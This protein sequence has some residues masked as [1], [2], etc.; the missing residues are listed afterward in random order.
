MEVHVKR[1]KLFIIVF[2]LALLTVFLPSMCLAGAVVTN[3][4][5]LKAKMDFNPGAV[6]INS[7]SRGKS[8]QVAQ[9][10]AVEAEEVPAVE[11]LTISLRDLFELVQEKNAEIRSK[12]LE[13]KNSGEV[14]NIERAIFEPEFVS[15]YQHEENRYRTS[16]KEKVSLG[17]VDIFDERNNDLDLAIEGLVQ[18]GAQLRLGYKMQD[19]FNTLT[20][21]EHEMK[22]FLGA[23]LTQPLLKNGGVDATMARIRITEADSDVEFQTYRQQQINTLSEAASAYW[24]LYFSQEKYNIR[25]TS[26]QNAEKILED[27]K[28]RVRTG[29]MAETEVLEAEAGVSFRKS[30]EV[31]ARQDIISTM[32]ELRTLFSSSAADKKIEIKVADRIEIDQLEL[33]LNSSLERASK[34][35]PEYVASLRKLEREDV[36]VA[37]AKNQR[38]PQ[39]DLKSSYGLNGLDDS[40]GD[41]N[42]DNVDGNF[43]SWSVGV[44]LRIPIGGGIKSRSELAIAKNR[45]Q[46]ALLEAKTVEVAVVNIID[47]AIRNVH[48]TL[49]QVRHYGNVASFNKRLLEAEIAR[50]KE[51]KSNSRLVLD[52]EEELNMAKEA[53][54]ES[55]VNYKKALL[56]LE[57][58]EGSLLLNSSLEVMEA[59]SK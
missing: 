54:I 16:T 28:E 15:A 29:K 2:Q 53:E 17:F 56:G 48:S 58:A 40:L 8:F 49:E 19:L 12:H 9:L 25:M 30:L 33:S 3:G 23:S 1:I 52:K 20:G 7:P 39:L 18:T 50:L 22:T 5:P 10:S 6:E 4:S 43:P 36:R 13:W 26:V 57:V 55:F 31:Q 59:D 45:K 42:R 38:W 51:G 44:E 21:G 24:D 34:L 41:S 11:M 14:V 32:N 47:T 35:N 37:F 27:S 46:Q